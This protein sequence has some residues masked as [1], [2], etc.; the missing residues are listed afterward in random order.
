MT[1]SQYRS[2][3]V[4][5]KTIDSIK[6][7]LKFLHDEHKATQQEA[8]EIRKSNTQHF[9]K[10]DLDNISD[11]KKL[12]NDLKTVCERFAPDSDDEEKK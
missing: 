8:Q 10:Y 2:K 6:D 3:H 1:K 12:I 4:V 5:K 11:E 7:T 9:M